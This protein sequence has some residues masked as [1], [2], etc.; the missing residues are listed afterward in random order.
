MPQGSEMENVTISRPPRNRHFTEFWSLRD[1]NRTNA[2][3]G[4]SST[5]AV[6][7]PHAAA[8]SPF[9]YGMPPPPPWAYGHY[10]HGYDTPPRPPKRPSP[11]LPSSDPPEPA[12][13]PSIYPTIV[14]FFAALH[15]VA[16][17]ASRNLPHWAK[18]FE[19]H[20]FMH[21]DELK[22][23]TTQEIQETLAMEEKGDANFIR[24][25]VDAE[26]M[27]V[28]KAARRSKRARKE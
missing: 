2:S 24:M 9:A 7:G 10:Y 13:A 22:G 21:I 14:D 1:N 23:W 25:K 18:V 26:I 4:H 8:G 3:S 12:T 15:G 27:R 17:N 5:P 16:A 11:S 6:A 20:H 28:D 19:V